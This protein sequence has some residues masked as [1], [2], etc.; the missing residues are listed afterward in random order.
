MTE[1]TTEATKETPAPP[2]AETAS[3]DL[4]PVAEAA[5]NQAAAGPD[6]VGIGS[7]APDGVSIPATPKPIQDSPSPA[8]PP[9]A[10]A[11]E[12]TAQLEAELAAVKAARA[13]MESQTKKVLDSQRLSWLKRR[14]ALN[15][16]DH[17]LL[18][19]APDVDADTPQGAAELEAW[20]QSNASLF[21][22]VKSSIP[23]KPQLVESMVQGGGN[24]VWG[25]E[26][27]RAIIRRGLGDE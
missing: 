18:T 2:Q 6:P 7:A 3:P 10:S 14:G 24:S 26:Q 17:H 19:L 21:S 20:T 16:G 9:A 23:T 22:P 13:Q 8:T 4:S 1:E 11:S 25:P 5:K 12:L 15:I 27:A